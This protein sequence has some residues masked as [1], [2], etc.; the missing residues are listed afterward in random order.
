MSNEKL[1]SYTITGIPIS[2]TVS[3]EVYNLN[4]E[5]FDSIQKAGCKLTIIKNKENI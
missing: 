5:Y 4:K 3:M 1:E 2:C